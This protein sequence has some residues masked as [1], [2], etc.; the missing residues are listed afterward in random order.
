MASSRHV[1]FGTLSS[2]QSLLYADGVLLSNLL[3]N[4][5]AYPPRW[6][7]V[8]AEEIESISMLY[9]PFS[10][11]YPGNSFGGVMSMYTKMPQ[12]LEMH[13]SY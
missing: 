1:L 10:A 11:L 3:G 7:M 8:S 6:G 13:A 2:A 5:Y 12:K 4:S 9:G